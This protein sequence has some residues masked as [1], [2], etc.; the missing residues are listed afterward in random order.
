M[1]EPEACD[2]LRRIS[3]AALR[4]SPP[5]SRKRGA[6]DVEDIHQSS[7]DH[8]QPL[9][10]TYLQARRNKTRIEDEAAGPIAKN[11]RNRQRDEPLIILALHHKSNVFAA[12]L[13][14][15]FVSASVLVRQ[16]QHLAL[17]A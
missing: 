10:R 2:F 14:L 9:T 17:V 5:G 4:G 15:L 1:D 13:N 7:R 11:S 6:L 12:N 16:R 3:R 8:Q